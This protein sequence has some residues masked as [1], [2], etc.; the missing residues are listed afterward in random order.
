[1]QRLQGEWSAR[2]RNIRPR[3]RRKLESKRKL[4][5]MVF[6]VGSCVIPLLR[7]F[8][9]FCC[10]DKYR[11]LRISTLNFGSMSVVRSVCSQKRRRWWRSQ[12]LLGPNRPGSWTLSTQSLTTLPSGELS[13]RNLVKN[14][15]QP[16][17][18]ERQWVL[19]SSN[20]HIQFWLKLHL[21][22]SMN[23]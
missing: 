8:F 13:H 3:Q 22:C 16:S 5:S 18:I 21:V 12:G 11:T 9:H 14:H 4:A 2:L 19:R 20:L 6:L 1:M 17:S 10:V 15:Q 7:T 23:G